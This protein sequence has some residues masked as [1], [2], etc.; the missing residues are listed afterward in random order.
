[1]LMDVQMPQMDGATATRQIRQLGPEVAQPYIIALTAHGLAGDRERFLRGGMDDYLSKPI[2]LEAL[3]Q[4]LARVTGS[5]VVA[6]EPTLAHPGE[7]QVTPLIAWVVI[8][9]LVNTLGL[10]EP[11]VIAMML[12]LIEEAIPPQIAE[13]EAAIAAGDR[14]RQRESAHRLRGGCLQLGAQALAAISYQ[15]ERAGGK[16]DAQMLVTSLHFCYSATHDL[17]KRKATSE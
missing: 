9:Q 12:R 11:E 4:A 1:V 8:E 6:A 3:Q 2:Q 16:A 10:T 5:L 14:T 7:R 17:L 15:L 13:L